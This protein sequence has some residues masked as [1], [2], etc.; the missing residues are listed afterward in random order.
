MIY[1][2]HWGGYKRRTTQQTKPSPWEESHAVCLSTK[3]GGE[4]SEGG[5]RRGRREDGGG[6]RE[7]RGEEKGNGRECV[8]RGLGH[9]EG[10][11]EERAG[12]SKEEKEERS[13]QNKG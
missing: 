12:T 10:M 11:R 2:L 1:Y 13:K 6:R 9:Q 3:L 8:W 5:W 7:E 4:W